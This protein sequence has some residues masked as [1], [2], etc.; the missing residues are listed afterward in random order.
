M[1]AG[2]QLGHVTRTG[3]S[4]DCNQWQSVAISGAPAAAS[5]SKP[6][7]ESVTVKTA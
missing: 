5:R 2:P 4:I 6:R 1:R 7:P 3:E